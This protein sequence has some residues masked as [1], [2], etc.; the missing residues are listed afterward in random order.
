VQLWLGSKNENISTIG[1]AENILA[2]LNYQFSY[3]GLLLLTKDGMTTYLR[4][5]FL[6]IKQCSLL[7]S[8]P[9]PRSNVDICLGRDH[10]MLH[11]PHHTK[12]VRDDHIRDL[13]RRSDE[14]TTP[15]ATEL[16]TSSRVAARIRIRLDATESN[17]YCGNK[18]PKKK[19]C[20]C[21]LA[22]GKRAGHRIGSVD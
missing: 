11:L 21:E 10:F 17:I 13:G 22:R 5:R 8:L 16:R 6:P 15:R 1:P 4:Q 7:D 19:G 12:S 20:G 14:T 9:T 3:T 2:H 18:H